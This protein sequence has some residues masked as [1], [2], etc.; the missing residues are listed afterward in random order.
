MTASPAP[1]P[2]DQFPGLFALP[3]SAVG[4][5]PDQA[6]Q[7]DY[8]ADLQ[9]DQLVD[10]VVSGRQRH[11]L[12]PA[13]QAR[14]DSVPA[15]QRRQA[16]VADLDDDHLRSAMQAFGDGLARC[17]RQ[18]QAAAQVRHQQQSQRWRLNAVASY[19]EVVETV[20]TALENAAPSSP[21]LLDW[22][23]WLRR[24]RASPGFVS[25]ATGAR[26]L[27]AEL[28]E[29]RYTL[30]ISGDA[31]TAAPF[32]G[33]EDLAAATLATFERFASGPVPPHQ[34]DLRPGAEMNDMHQAILDLVAQLFPEVFDRVAHFLDSHGTVR[35]PSIDVV[36]RELQFVLAWLAF[37]APMRHA[38]L[39]FGLPDMAETHRL[40]AAGAFD[41]LLA[42]T[43]V[44]VGK[45]PITNDIRLGDD[46]L[47]LVVTGPNQGGKTTFARTVGQLYHLAALGLPVPGRAVSLHPPDSI[48]THFDRGDRAADL[49]S[50]LEEEVT[51]MTELLTRVTAR[52]VVILNEMFSS[53]TFVDAR[54]MSAD[55]L[56]SVLDADAVTV[57]VTFIDE[58]STLDPRI[59][60]LV[61]GVDED[62]V[63]RRTF[64]VA[65]GRADG[66]AHALALA[67]KY[68]LTHEQLRA[69]L[70]AGA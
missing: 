33:Q 32:D 22:L 55:V 66:R 30:S 60:S 45:S 61:T 41:V 67:A 13:F 35:H 56:R 2:D 34:F 7:P 54:T 48:L 1:V 64:T 14:L 37:I 52:S 17:E 43:L 20:T 51:R 38:G 26:A 53:T 63:T 42:H 11:N 70:G 15:I 12:G 28:G 47:M 25:M 19:A 16:V 58:L 57:C 59:V 5:L 10:A 39:P 69:R 24:Y 6:P 62:D 21:G 8:F 9:L 49:H 29:L 31:V 18:F 27:L 46:E 3:G 36:E 40:E 44:A 23:A 65:R 50:R 68:G 4:E